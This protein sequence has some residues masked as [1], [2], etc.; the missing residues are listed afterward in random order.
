MNSENII[1]AFNVGKSY[2]SSS[3]VVKI[4]SGLNF[5]IRKG[6]I[7]GLIGNNGSGKTTL[8]KMLSGIIKPSDGRIEI[9]GKVNS[10]IDL[11]Q[12]FDIELTGREN[13][14]MNLMINGYSNATIAKMENQ[15][16]QIA[17]IGNGVDEQV[18]NYSSGMM[19]RLGFALYTAI[20][21]DVL[22]L[23]EIISVGDY[24]FRKRSN[25][26]IHNL[27]KSGTTIVLAVH[28]LDIIRTICNKCMLLS[29]GEVLF[30]EVNN[31]ISFYRNILIEKDNNFNIENEQLMF[32]QVQQDS[33]QIELIS[34]RT[35]SGQYI[36]EYPSDLSIKVFYKIKRQLKCG[37]TLSINTSEN[38]PLLS[39]SMFYNRD[40]NDIINS[41]KPGIYS[42]TTTIPSSNFSPG[43]YSLDITFHNSE[44]TV[45]KNYK[46]SLKFTITS[47]LFTKLFNNNL[48]PYPLL[49]TL[50]WKFQKIE[51]KMDSILVSIEKTKQ[52][53][54]SGF[55]ELD[56]VPLNIVNC[57]RD[58]YLAN[59]TSNEA[60]KNDITIASS[61]VNV[62]AKAQEKIITSL[63]EY[64]NNQFKGYKVILATYFVK[65]KSDSSNVGFHHDPT[66]TDPEKYD[67]FT[68]WIPLEN[69]GDGDGE[70]MI[71]PYSHLSSNLINY[72]NHVPKYINDARDEDAV[73]I[74]ANAG[75]PTLFFNR[76]IHR[77]KSN[78]NRDVRIAISVKICHIDAS[79][80]SYFDSENDDL[81]E[82]YN[83]G[84]FFYLREDWNETQRPDAYKFV[85]TLP[86]K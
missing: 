46:K 78:I 80:Y 18:K 33:E 65:F 53:Y 85:E 83:Q 57:L 23:D 5:N 58:F 40:G 50:D 64:L 1:S 56:P 76:C 61:D 12:N 49:P 4:F 8:L 35:N 63:K 7:I 48:P 75:N 59:F 14:R 79:L 28:D 42:V 74:K 69:V 52:L 15:I 11:G 70:L 55:V 32:M 47:K 26:I 39:S 82:K 44:E 25:A 20:P 3:G 2:I 24:N 6:E 43:D 67:D 10:V 19:L 13:V 37:I 77:S 66:F 22:L 71:I 17:D 31:V 30:G 36:I 68:L 73:V 62:R 86:R 84:E 81:V 38:L 21:S 60:T 72:F 45:L 27:I 34:I 51:S 16:F 54:D 9:F 29:R 41:H